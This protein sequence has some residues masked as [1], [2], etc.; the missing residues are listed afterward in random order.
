[1]ANS[2]CCSPLVAHWESG[3]WEV[4]FQLPSRNWP[5]ELRFSASLDCL[6]AFVR[7]L[8]ERSELGLAPQYPLLCT[9]HL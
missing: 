8:F 7:K 9:F 4:T 6:A 1:M 5:S 3:N 2:I